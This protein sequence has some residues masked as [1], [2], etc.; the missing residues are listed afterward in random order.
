MVDSFD[1]YQPTTAYTGN[2]TR[3]K[4]R[5]PSNPR[6]TL[7][8]APYDIIP[9]SDL[10]YNLTFEY[11]NTWLVRSIYPSKHRLASK[12]YVIPARIIGR[13]GSG[14]WGETDRILG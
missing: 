9:T 2:V 10:Q 11:L 1:N 7:I 13:D 8:Q 6:P 14:E 4:T 12:S 5:D 3:T